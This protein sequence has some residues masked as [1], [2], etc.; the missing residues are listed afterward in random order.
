[1]V[2][3][4][5][6][7]ITLLVA[8]APVLLMRKMD[9]D[10]ALREGSKSVAATPRTQRRL[11]A[12]IA[13]EIALS[14]VLL[15]GAGLFIGSHSRLKQVALGFDPHDVLT[16][17]ITAGG[18]QRSSPND[19]R[20]FYR[21]V[22]RRAAD[23]GGIRQVALASDMPLAGGEWIPYTVAGHP[24]PARGAEPESLV[25]IVSPGYFEVL[26]IPLQAG[27]AFT[28]LDSELAPRV[29][30]VNENLVRGAFAGENPIGKV[31]AILP[32]GDSSIPVGPVEIVGV[33][34][35]SRE[36]GLN[37]VAFED[38]YLPF[39]QNPQ[40]T[41]SLAAKTG[42]PAAGIAASLRKE[43]QNLDPDSALYNPRTLED[44]LAQQFRGERFH[45]MLVSIFAA[46]A[47]LLA[48]VGIYGAIA[49]SVA[50]RTREFG[51]RMALGA[52]PAAIRRL[53]LARTTRLALTGVACGL[54][55]SL[56]LGQL[57][58]SALYLVP[59]QHSG[60]IYGVGI[61]DPLSLLAAAAIVLALAA[62]AS[63]APA[64]R[65]ARVEPS[66]ALRDE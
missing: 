65:A 61:R 3:A 33:V 22:M 38:I 35:N 16:V 26:R 41:M 46:L 5:S 39:A 50:Q 29:A 54:G 59:H 31:L 36:L 8:M 17:R 37:E 14:F 2:L 18:A 57:L 40:R 64:G 53:T 49:F 25:R 13:A 6:L 55:V 60:L 62:M 34:S 63:L 19:R 7:S 58:R 15:F 27:R 28:E 66:A 10:A 11:N 23:T 45:L 20:P 21:E 56:I 32:G 1:L 52:M 42:G 30:M 47:A 24:L 12:L 44:M 51:L 43:L 48:G 4:V 9:L